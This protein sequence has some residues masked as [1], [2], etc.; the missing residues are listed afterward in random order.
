MDLTRDPSAVFVDEADVIGFGIN[1]S[2][3]LLKV[4]VRLTDIHAASSSKQLLRQL[5]LENPGVKT[6]CLLPF[7]MRNFLTGRIV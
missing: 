5:N 2:P 7:S 3:W 4:P 6:G 1:I